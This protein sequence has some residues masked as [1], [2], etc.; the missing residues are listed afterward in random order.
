MAYYTLYIKFTS[1]GTH[2]VQDIRTQPCN[3]SQCQFEIMYNVVAD[4]SLVTGSFIVLNYGG[5]KFHYL[6]NRRSD[7][8]AHDGV[9]VNG[10]T[11]DSYNLLVFLLNGS[12]LPFTLPSNQQRIV[13]NVSVT[14]KSE[15]FRWLI[16]SIGSVIMFVYIADGNH[17]ERETH[18]KG[19]KHTGGGCFQCWFASS[20]SA[21]HCTVI[22]HTLDEVINVSL[23]ERRGDSAYGCTTVEAGPYYGVAFSYTNNA[24]HGRPYKAGKIVVKAQK[25]TLYTYT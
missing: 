22:V 1:A 10:L 3:S 16:E 4:S 11:R 6:V 2:F 13:V 14:A 9:S 25:G 8:G 24:M 7:N 15:Y 20:S 23:F 21:S 18:L 5:D 12:G 17:D 19:F